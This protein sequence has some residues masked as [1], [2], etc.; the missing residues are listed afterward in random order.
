M[1]GRTQSGRYGRCVGGWLEKGNAV[2]ERDEF[3]CSTNESTLPGG[4]VVRS[5][6]AKQTRP[7]LRRNFWYFQHHI[8]HTHTHTH[9]HAHEGTTGQEHL[10]LSVKPH[11][12]AVLARSLECQADLSGIE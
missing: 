3:P 6:K 9:A 2:G 8:T 12:G 4:G 11:L 7:V 1:G 5:C 10:G